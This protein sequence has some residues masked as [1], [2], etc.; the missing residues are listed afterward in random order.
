LF[1]PVL[2]DED[3]LFEGIALRGDEFLRAPLLH[4]DDEFVL[5]TVARACVGFELFVVTDELIV[6]ASMALFGGN[7]LLDCE[8]IFFRTKFSKSF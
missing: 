3:D 4:F 8:T 2:T 1:L 7:V 6:G 5:V